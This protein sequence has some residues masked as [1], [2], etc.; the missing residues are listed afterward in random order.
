MEDLKSEAVTA[1]ADDTHT[2]IVLLRTKSGEAD[3]LVSRISQVAHSNNATN[4]LARLFMIPF[5]NRLLTMRSDPS[6]SG[7]RCSP[8][9]SSPTSS[10]SFSTATLPR[11]TP[12]RSCRSSS[13][14][15]R[16]WNALT[17]RLWLFG[18]KFIVFTF[19]RRGQ[20]N[21]TTKIALNCGN[22]K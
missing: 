6:A 16:N 4:Q 17:D 10:G 15:S 11:K 18:N 19:S 14:W 13:T 7:P 12:A 5:P 20:Q 3:K 2:N 9:P 21:R 22:L 8:P 1:S